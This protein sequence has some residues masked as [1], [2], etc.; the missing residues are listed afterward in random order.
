MYKL[1]TLLLLLNLESKLKHKSEQR[2][3][4][5]KRKASFSVDRHKP[6]QRSVRVSVCPG[7]SDKLLHGSCDRTHHDVVPLHLGL[8]TGQLLTLQLQAAQGQKDI[9]TA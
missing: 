3:R 9:N 6:K 5:R 2:E 4:E 7:Q 1:E 8:L